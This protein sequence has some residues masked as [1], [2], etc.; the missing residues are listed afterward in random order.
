MV[1]LASGTTPASLATTRTPANIAMSS[2]TI[3]PRVVW[4]LR[5]STGLYAGTAF[6]MASMPVIAVEPDENARG[7]SRAV[8]PSVMGRWWTGTGWK[9]WP[10]ACTRPAITSAAMAAMNA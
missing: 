4:A 7:T 9:P 8:T 10:A 6:E 2:P 1:W 5:H 3:Q